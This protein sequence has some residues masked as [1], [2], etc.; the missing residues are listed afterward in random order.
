MNKQQA[1]LYTKNNIHEEVPQKIIAFFERF[2]KIMHNEPT[3][4]VFGSVHEGSE[5][6]ESSAVI[7]Q[8]RIEY[9]EVARV[10]PKMKT[11]SFE[12]LDQVYLLPEGSLKYVSIV[13]K[14][15]SSVRLEIRSSIT[16]TTNFFNLI[17]EHK[18][19]S[20]KKEKP[21]KTVKCSN[22]GAS[23]TVYQGEE[24]KCEYCDT[25]LVGY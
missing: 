13:D 24:T 6:I 8:D 21:S 25:P 23:C 22:C 5:V 11:V 9:L 19:G 17:K 2:S 1:S 12:Y 18:D 7:L 10:F 16:D 15:K 4:A 14:S 20:N 3:I